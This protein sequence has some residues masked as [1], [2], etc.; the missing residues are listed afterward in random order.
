MERKD[1][2]S[3]ITLWANRAVA[4]VVVILLYTMP[5]LLNWYQRHR[6]LTPDER[7]ALIIAFYLCAVVT[8]FA[9]W[10]IE[11][12]LGNVLSGQVFIREN[13]RRIGRLGICCALISLICLPAAFVYYPLIFMVVIMAFLC[14]AVSVVRSVIQA[15]VVIREENDLTI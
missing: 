7:I 9:L 5:M 11:K 12:M 14:L 8:L 13:V 2:S 3:R 15:A 6:G 4:G 1:L 10:Q